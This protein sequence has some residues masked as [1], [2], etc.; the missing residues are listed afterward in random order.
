MDKKISGRKRVVACSSSAL[1][2]DSDLPSPKRCGVTIKTVDKW[3]ADN[4]KTLNTMTWLK[5]NKVD[6][7]HIATLKCSVCFH[8][9]DKLCSVQNYNPA[10][11]IGSTNLC[12]STF[13]EHAASDMH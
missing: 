5:Y 13:K 8:F 6:C 10:Y 3:I 9:D 12:T 4:D 7:D 11:V 1:D 2:T